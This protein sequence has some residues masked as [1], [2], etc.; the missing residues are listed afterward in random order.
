MREACLLAQLYLV[1]GQ[2]ED[3]LDTARAVRLAAPADADAHALF[4]LL[5]E[6]EG[7]TA[8]TASDLSEAYLELLKCDPASD[9]AVLGAP[10]RQQAL[11]YSA[12]QAEQV[13]KTVE[14]QNRKQKRQG[15]P[16]LT[17]DVF[18]PDG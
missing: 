18:I 16:H 6:S 11:Q 2:P 4:I 15:Q 10:P 13:F 1:G 17:S 14:H 5:Q 8:E 9:Y 7:P 3:A 12:V